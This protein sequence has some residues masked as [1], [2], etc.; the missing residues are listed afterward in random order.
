MAKNLLRY[1]S[2][3]TT[4]IKA[5]AT[6]P[7][8]ENMISWAKQ[9]TL[10]QKRR[11]YKILGDHRMV[12]I[13]F[14]DIA[15]RFKNRTGGF[16][17]ILKL[18]QRRGDNAQMVIFELTEIKEKKKKVKLEKEAKPEVKPGIKPELKPQ[19]QIKEK[20]A[21]E[22]RPSKETKILEKPPVSKKPTKTFLGGLRKIFKKERDSL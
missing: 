8:V 1:E 20:P 12:N 14:N 17:R 19:E 21:I 9:N 15:P 11:V 7:I 22:T 3:K 18:G 16:T 10:A 4:L 6:Q 5:K 2:L 13:L